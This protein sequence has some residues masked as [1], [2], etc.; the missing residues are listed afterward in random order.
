VRRSVLESADRP[1]RSCICPRLCCVG[2]ATRKKFYIAAAAGWGVLLALAFFGIVF[3]VPGVACAHLFEL[4]GVLW[5]PSAWVRAVRKR[6]LDTP[7]K[8]FR[9]RLWNWYIGIGFAGM[10]LAAMS[11]AFTGHALSGVFVSWLYWFG[12]TWISW[13][14]AHRRAALVHDPMGVKTQPKQA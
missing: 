2:S 14:I 10:V 1:Y 9:R 13:L 5:I 8:R 4:F 3:G 6:S 12:W 7:F 11:L